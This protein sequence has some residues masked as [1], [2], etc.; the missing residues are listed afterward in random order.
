MFPDMRKQC[1]S[2]G[3]RHSEPVSSTGDFS[4]RHQHLR[5]MDPIKILFGQPINQ[6]SFGVGFSSSALKRS[7][8]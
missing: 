1:P 6:P 4:R 8:H 5:G 7:R 2:D 3:L